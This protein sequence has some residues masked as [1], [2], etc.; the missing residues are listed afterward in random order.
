MNK[1]IAIKKLQEVWKLA[2]DCEL[3]SKQNLANATRLQREAESALEM[4]GSS[5][6]RGR[7][8]IKVS[9]EEYLNIL[10]DITK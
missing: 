9:E 2:K 8:A 7:K 4:L 3:V 6:G 1:T 5:S 10:A